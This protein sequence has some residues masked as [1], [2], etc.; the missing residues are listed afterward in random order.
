VSDN[1]Y[2]LTGTLIGDKGVFTNARRFAYR[3]QARDG[4]ADGFGV[5]TYPGGTTYSGEWAAGDRHGHS[6]NRCTTGAVGFCRFD[7]GERKQFAAL[8]ADGARGYRGLDAADLALA[9]SV[10]YRGLN[11]ADL[12]LAA[13]AQPAAVRRTALAGRARS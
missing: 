2:T 9:A 12:S 8:S 5:F 13:A 6:V 3:G 10:G 11:A 1:T 7:R 4:K